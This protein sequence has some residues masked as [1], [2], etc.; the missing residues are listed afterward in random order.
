MSRI[1]KQPIEIPSGVDV[2]VGEDAVVVVK[3]PRGE[4]SQRVHPEMRLLREEDVLRVERPTDEGSTAASMGSR[5]RYREHGRRRHEGLREA[6]RDRR[7]QVPRGDEGQGAGGPGGVL[8]P[9]HGAR[10]RGDRV[11]DADADPDRGAGQRQATRGGGRGQHPEDP[12]ARALQG[13]GSAT[14]TS[15]SAR[16]PARPRRVRPPDGCQDQTPSPGPPRPRAQERSPGPRSGA[17]GRVPLQPTH[18]RAARGRRCGAHADRRIGSRRA[19]GRGWKG[20]GSRRG[21][22]TAPAKAV[23]QLLAERAK[24]AGIDRVVFD[25]GGRLFHGR[26]AALAEGAREKGLQI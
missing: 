6:A 26:V 13:Q 2:T 16:R 5:D 14:R 18:L 24:A 4:L 10:D 9:G 21:N 20:E 15:T 19:G 1:G 11:R 7:R 8:A 25:R 22:K 12:Q 17:S 23:G 3:G